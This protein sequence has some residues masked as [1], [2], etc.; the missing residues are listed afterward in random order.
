MFILD[1]RLA[2][3]C[4]YLALLKSGEKQGWGRLWALMKDDASF[5][6]CKHRDVLL[7]GILFEGEC[8]GGRLG[9]DFCER[10]ILC[11]TRRAPREK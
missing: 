11:R 4:G 5:L 9:V 2:Q 7:W 1:R 6:W 8:W 3:I 10:M